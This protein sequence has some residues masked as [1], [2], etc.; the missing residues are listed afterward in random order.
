VV[1][2]QPPSSLPDRGNVVFRGGM[3]VETG[4][5]ADYV[6]HWHLVP[7]SNAG[8]AV[9]QQLDSD[10]PAWL[11]VAGQHVMYVRPRAADFDGSGWGQGD[12][13]R[14][15][16]D[17][18]LSFGERSMTGWTVLHSGFPW[19]EKTAITVEMGEFGDPGLSMIVDGKSSRWSVLEWTQHPPFGHNRVAPS[20]P[21]WHEV[22]TPLRDEGCQGHI[23]PDP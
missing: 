17:F 6:E 16:L 5:H 19:R 21:R 3:L 13:L 14:A 4:I 22:A 8:F 15:Q 2:F 20:T 11:L 10:R 18:E 23:V 9:L 12:A 7:G 1:D